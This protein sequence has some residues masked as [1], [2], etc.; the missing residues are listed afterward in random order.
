[1]SSPETRPADRPRAGIDLPAV[2]LVAAREIREFLR[3]KPVW[4]STALTVV[5]VVLAIVLPHVL[6]GGTKTYTVAVTPHPSTAVRAAVTAAAHN[7][8]AKA[9]L[10]TVSDTAAARAAVRG[11]GPVHADIGVDTAGSGRVIIDRALPEDSTESKALVVQGIARALATQRAIAESG[12]SVQQ[13]RAVLDPQPLSVVN[14]RPPPTSNAHRA[15]A[16]GGGVV[17]LLLVMWYGTGLLVSVVNEKS[18]RVVEVVLSSLRPVELLAG[19]VLGTAALVLG[20]GV[21]L[22]AAALIAANAVGSDVLAGSGVMTVVSSGVWI[23]L[24]F[25]LYAALFAAMGSLVSRVEDAQTV[26][27]PLQLP[28]MI[29]Y[30]VIFTSLGS[31]SANV[32]LQVLAYIPFTAPMDMPALA[33]T[34]GA[35]WWQVLISMLITVVAIV[36]TTRVA[37]Q[38]FARSILRTGQRVRLRSVLGAGRADSDGAPV[39]TAG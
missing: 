21:L 7:A 34:G 26:A 18:T 25:L 37:G 36:V 2:R 15:L 4:I 19:K 31:G 17:F 27:M 33:A 8:G 23:V 35:Q 10:V 16:V 14:L 3:G 32:V 30:A 1:M 29:G 22:V 5:G 28:L 39:G 24:G 9:K 6:A 38:I 13:V 20:Q 12:L 11:S